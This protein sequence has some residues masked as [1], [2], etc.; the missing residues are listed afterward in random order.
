[1][2]SAPVRNAAVNSRSDPAMP[3][4][5]AAEAASPEAAPA[6]TPSAARSA[7]S[8]PASTVGASSPSHS[9]EPCS[10]DSRQAPFHDVSAPGLHQ[11]PVKTKRAPPSN[12][13]AAVAAASPA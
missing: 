8:P 10:A 5:G 4:P 1:M 3:S 9:T 12:S 13:N 2:G 7:P 11:L 6:A